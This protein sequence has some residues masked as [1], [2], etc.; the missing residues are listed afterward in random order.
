[1]INNSQIKTYTEWDIGK[2]CMEQFTIPKYDLEEHCISF[3]CEKYQIRVL[4]DGMT[5]LSEIQRRVVESILPY[6]RDCS[7]VYIECDK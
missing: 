1:M 3:G 2:P 5:P 6:C 4:D 7:V